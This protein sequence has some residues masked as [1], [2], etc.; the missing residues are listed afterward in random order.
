LFSISTRM[1]ERLGDVI[2]KDVEGTS[3]LRPRLLKPKVSN[4]SLLRI[5]KLTSTQLP[6]LVRMQRLQG[7]KVFDL[8]QCVLLQASR[9]LLLDFWSFKDV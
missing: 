3:L 7:L 2:V 1:R 9:I 8:T 5:E 4:E 6:L